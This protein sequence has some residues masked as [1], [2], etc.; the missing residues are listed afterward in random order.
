M[1]GSLDEEFSLTRK[2]IY[3]DSA[4]IGA[5]PVSTIRV[6]ECY[7]KD[8]C[9]WLQGKDRWREGID[10]WTERVDGSKRLFARVIGA[11]ADE[12]AF[13]PNTTTGINTVFSMLPLKAREN[14]VMTDISYP[15]GA[16]VCLKQR[17]KGVE[18]RFAKNVNGEVRIEG[19]EK[20][21][22]DETVAVMV[23]Q[24]GWHNGFLHNLKAISQIAHEHGAF[25][26]VDAV[27][28]AGGLKIDVKREGIDF[29]ATSTYK[30]L[31]GGPY[32]QSAGYLYIKEEFIDAFQPPF[33]GNQT[34]EDEQFQTNIYDRFDLYNVRYSEGIRRFQ[35]YPRYEL[36][37]VAAENSMRILLNY[38]IESIEKHI[39][40]LGTLMI[41]GLLRSG[42]RL[43]T[44]IEAEKRLYVNVKVKNNRELEKQLYKNNI[45]VSARIGGLRISPHFYNTEEEIEVFLDKLNEITR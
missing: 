15:M 2:L 27:Q 42:F 21:I 36:A 29:L 28:S 26:I 31:L 37:Y 18:T 11:K 13:I 33:I 17:E 24:A 30:W 39:K 14:I 8:R 22:D 6:I 10:R 16:V 5:C 19:F 44:P 43:Q 34:I 12:V 25:L 40:K 32:T 41:E 3:L 38:G 7:V 23:D 9:N 35:I 1:N 4:A 45:V 20:A